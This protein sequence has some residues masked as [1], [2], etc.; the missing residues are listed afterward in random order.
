MSSNSS[1]VKREKNGKLPSSSSVSQ[2]APAIAVIPSMSSLPPSSHYTLTYPFH[3]V[4]A[5]DIIKYSKIVGKWFAFEESLYKLLDD[6]NTSG[7]EST[8][9][10]RSVKTNFLA[11]MRSLMY[12]KEHCYI[13]SGSSKFLDCFGYGGSSLFVAISFDMFTEFES[14]EFSEEGCRYGK[15]VLSNVDESIID[16]KNKRLIS[17]RCGS[18]QDYFSFDATVVYMNCTIFDESTVD[19]FPLI[20][21]ILRLSGRLQPG[22][23]LII[24]TTCMRL[25]T[26]SCEKLGFAGFDCLYSQEL[27]VDSDVYLIWI[28]K[29]KTIIPTRRK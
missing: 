2:A 21:L 14:I 11:L 18:A 25:E 20:S 12:I 1:S 9:K 3:S 23:L 17:F 5:N 4:D 15:Q 29:T 24:V 19:E 16:K 27:E 13:D 7:G 10:Y 8:W 6:N 28:L 22:S 26:A